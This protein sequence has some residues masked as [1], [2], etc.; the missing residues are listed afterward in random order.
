[1]THEEQITLVKANLAGSPNEWQLKVFSLFN[2]KD[3]PSGYLISYGEL[4]RQANH[5]FGLRLG[6]RNVAWLRGKLYGILGHD[7]DIPI[8]HIAN[9]DDAESTKDHPHTQKINRE[10]RTAEGSYPKPK[11]V[12]K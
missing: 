10:K 9:Q 7:T 1:M 12:T 6:P 8:H 4:A 2:D 3:I 5:K 11:W